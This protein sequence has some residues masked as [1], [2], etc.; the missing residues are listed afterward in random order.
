[1]I[2]IFVG[3]LAYQTGQTELEELFWAFGTVQRVTIVTEPNSGRSR[4]FAFVEMPDRNEGNNAIAALNGAEVGGRTV[5][6]NEA[7]PRVEQIGRHSRAFA[8]KR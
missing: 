2:R 5:I 8:Y 6:V 4:G 7:R 3:N 1:M